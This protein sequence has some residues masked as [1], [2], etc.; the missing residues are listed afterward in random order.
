MITIAVGMMVKNESLTI[1]RTLESLLPLKPDLVVIT[2]TGSTDDTIVKAGLFLQDKGIKY[3]IYSEQFVDFGFNR[4]LVLRKCFLEPDI[5]W[6]LMIDADETLVLHDF[7][8]DDLR[9]H[10]CF[11]VKLEAAPIIYS[12]PRLTSN[13]VPWKYV[14]VTHEYLDT[15]GMSKGYCSNI[16]LNQHNDSFRRRSNQKLMDDVR[17]LK[18]GIEF[19]TD[20]FLVARYH[21]YLAN[22]YHSLGNYAKAIEHYLERIAFKGWEEEIFYSHYQIGKIYTQSEPNNLEKIILHH[23]LAFDAAPWRI[24]S[25]HALKIVLEQHKLDGLVKELILPK[26][27]VM[28]RPQSGLFLEEHLYYA[29]SC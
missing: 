3:K 24:E 14:G 27:R 29:Y 6:V 17:L 5:D 25:L 18:N 20:K 21:F 23:L 1:L 2:D 10:Q 19:S 11:D 9:F 13:K 15:T 8:R 22:T 4:T 12:L 7:N 26:L 16:M 28:R